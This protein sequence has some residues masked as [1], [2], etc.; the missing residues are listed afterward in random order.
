M[1]NPVHVNPS[2]AARHLTVG[3]SD[4]LWVVTVIMGISMLLTLVWSKF[5]PRGTRAFH[6][7]AVAILT[8]STIAYFAMASNLGQ[9]PVRV[10]FRRGPDR[11]I[12]WVRYIQWFI[13]APLILLMLLLTTGFPLS[14]IFLT[15]FM[16]IVTVVSGLVGALTPTSYKWGF[17]VFG[18]LAL[19]FV[20]YT[21][22]AGGLRSRLLA[23]RSMYAR[24]GGHIALIWMLYPVC[25]AL[26]E[27]GN[28]LNVPHEMIFYSILDLFAGPIFLFMH[29]A[30]MRSIEY[31]SLGLQSG[32]ASDYIGPGGAAPLATEKRSNPV[33]N[34]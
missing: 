32:K 16:I 22:L 24:G 18:T 1:T 11:S 31:N 14:D 4:W 34:V 5:Q 10:E 29:L 23:S 30:A 26:S 3:A 13:N 21:L 27:G 20:V 12:F 6:H 2:S 28:I 15:I 19:I 7:L 17:F 8:V 25:W 33:S 9:T